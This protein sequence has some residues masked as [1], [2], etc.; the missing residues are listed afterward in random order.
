MERLGHPHLPWDVV[1]RRAAAD[2]M[3][4]YSP[5]YLVSLPLL[6][7]GGWTMPWV[8]R[9]ILLCA[10]YLL[11]VPPAARYAVTVAPLA[12]LALAVAGAAI[13]DRIDPVFR[14]RASAWT[15]CVLLFLPGWLYAGYELRRGG[16]LPVTAAAREAYL[17]PASVYRRSISQS[18]A[19]ERYVPIRSELS[20]AVFRAG[21]AARRPQRSRELRQAPDRRPDPRP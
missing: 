20:R 4:P 21:P 7:L 3:P 1:F 5:I 19:G 8:R 10:A 18:D 11:V 9:M 12:S 14:S 16:P 2:W 15:L 6:A 17:L 13:L